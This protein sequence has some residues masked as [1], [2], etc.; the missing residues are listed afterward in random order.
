MRI[1][2]A[3]PSDLAEIRAAYEQGRATQREQGS[4]GWPQFTDAAILGE[5]DAG[6]LFRL[7]DDDAIVGVFSVAYDDAAIWGS[8][9]RGTHV[10][11]HRKTRSRCSSGRAR[12]R[13]AFCKD[14]KHRHTSSQLYPVNTRHGHTALVAHTRDADRGCAP[15]HPLSSCPAMLKRSAIVLVA[16]VLLPPAA[17]A[18]HPTTLIESAARARAIVDAAVAAHGGVEALRAAQR[19][20]VV[21]RGSDFWRNQS[22]RVEPPYDSRDAFSELMLDVPA[23]RLVSRAAGAYPGDLMFSGRYVIDGE[24]SHRVL[25]TY[26][27]H[28]TLRAS[29]VANQTGML[30]TYLP[31]LAV[32]AAH[33]NRGSLRSLG[34]LRLS[35]GAIVDAIA[36]TTATG[37]VTL[38]FD[39]ETKR[40]RAV[41]NVGGDALAGDASFETEFVDYKPLNGVL[42]PARRI[43]YTAGE[44]TQDVQYVAATPNYT[45]PDS[46]LAIPSTSKVRAEATGA[47]VQELAPGVWSIRQFRAHVLAVAFND[48]VVVV[49]APGGATP[50]IREQIARLA[51]GK[52]I[53]YVIPTHHHDDH[54]GGLRDHIAAGTTV[55]TT[56]GNRAYIERMAAAHSALN[57]D[58]QAT[59]RRTPTI[60]TITGGRRVF[61]DGTRT[62]E[63]HDMGP[64]EHAKELLVAWIP[65]AGILYEGDMLNLGL[66]GDVPQNANMAATVSFAEWIKRRGWTVRTF[67][68]MHHPPVPAS[69]L[70]DILAQPIPR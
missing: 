66:N 16:A 41:L 39:T 51:P 44:K 21:L 33:D 70:T 56:P 52:P 24:R 36:T 67:L 58:A 30:F 4:T 42:L 48:Y 49:E 26:G 63:L 10:Y 62:L 11:L 43:T 6:R 45:V 2:P 60:E 19:I 5:I 31:Q 53:R 40:L 54:A 38:G 23:S 28:F 64:N 1:E 22:V 69:A 29:P 34:R 47:P 59:A 9:E 12:R 15:R 61:T 57:P 25:E 35:S 37:L 65:E 27:L 20:H 68:G 14:E 8:H 55:V 18:Q 17:R 32:Q 7:V 46:M 3:A 13:S 50:G